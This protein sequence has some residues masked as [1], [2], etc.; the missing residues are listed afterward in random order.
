MRRVISPILLWLLSF[1]LSAPVVFSQDSD[2]ER[3]VHGNTQFAIDL[4][5]RINPENENFVYSPYSISLAMAMA[6]GG[7]RGKTA[8]QMIDVLRFPIEGEKLHAAFAE[9]QEK[10]RKIQEQQKIELHVV[11]SFWPQVK[12]PFLEEYLELVR[13]RYRSEII[14]VD[15][16]SD[17]ESARKRINGWVETETEGRIKDIIHYPILPTTCWILANAIYFKGE[18]LSRFEKVATKKMPFYRQKNETTQVLMMQQ[19][20]DFNYGEDDSLQV[21]ELP[22]IGEEL[23]MFIV[24]PSA[25]DGLQSLEE[26]LTAEGLQWWAENLRRMPVAIYLPRF[27]VEYSKD[28]ID[29]LK[30]MGMVDAL[31]R[32]IAD[33][34]GLGGHPG[35]LYIEIAEHK[36]FIE[37]S[38]EGTEAAAATAVGCFPAGV[39]VLTDRG[40]MPIESVEPGARVYT[41]DLANGKWTMAKILKRRSYNY[42]GDMITISIGEDSIQSTGNQPF[43]VLRGDQ[44]SARPIPAEVT[45]EEQAVSRDG[46]WVEARD[47]KEGDVLKSKSRE[48]LVITEVYSCQER[49]NVYWLDVERYHNCAVHRLAILAHNGGEGEKKSAEPEPALFKADH[50]FLFLIRENTTGSILFMGRVIDPSTD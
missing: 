20:K 9:V 11:N 49:K 7:A 15:Y 37:T 43:Y 8:S 19:T 2:L 35:E 14:P 13:N 12:Y 28:L 26:S 6:Y 10:L 31:T 44:L 23:S 4:Y 16:L 39:D 38:E 5:Q 24:L 40:L 3:L 22:Y 25:I 34:S 30:A 50:P 27:K 21:L 17:P 46:R 29:T 18:W 45:K 47:L 33:F 1:T 42:H 32:G 41:C 48:G 36:A